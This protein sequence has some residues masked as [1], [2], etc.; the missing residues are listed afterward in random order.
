MCPS[1]LR[2]T[3][4]FEILEH[5]KKFIILVFSVVICSCNSK[6][7]QTVAIVD[8]VPITMQQIDAL[9]NEQLFHMLE[10]I[11]LIRKQALDEYIDQWVIAEEAKRRNVTVDKL[12]EREVMPL[13][14][15]SLIEKTIIELRGYV[16]DRIDPKRVY[17]CNT[18]FGREYL[19]QSLLLDLKSKYAQKLRENHKIK[20]FLNPPDKFRPKI[21]LKELDLHYKGDNKSKVT[22]I[23]IGNYECDGCLQAKPIFDYIISK[24][25]NK[26]KY[27]FCFYDV[28]PTMSSMAVEASAIQGKYWE[29][30]EKIFSH[31]NKTDTTTVIEYAKELGL[32][33]NK[34]Q[35]DL[36]SNDLK[37]R[38]N[39]N[40]NVMNKSK[41]TTIPT[42]VITGYVFNAPFNQ[43]DI[44]NFIIKLLND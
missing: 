26:I 38:I 13:L 15:D 33:V 4:F 30:H 39:R 16:P 40:I 2:D 25:G 36:N 11:Y 10:G 44:E 7:Q 5:M 8:G 18:A 23:F 32:N 12:L 6:K 19:R 29:M 42:I 1:N 14:T 3:L 21:S 43:W 34:F 9:I 17:D 41:I 22:F 35:H 27:G 37:D 31:H 20:I 28:H 24:Y